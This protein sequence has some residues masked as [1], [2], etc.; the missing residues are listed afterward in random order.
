MDRRK[1]RFLIAN[2]QHVPSFHTKSVLPVGK[3]EPLDVTQSKPQIAHYHPGSRV[4][5]LANG[6]PSLTKGDAVCDMNLSI[7]LTE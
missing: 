7:S 5:Q 4:K 1:P 6:S 2:G 3:D